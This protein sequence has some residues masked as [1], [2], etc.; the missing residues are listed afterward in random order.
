MLSS[1]LNFNNLDR[2][3]DYQHIYYNVDIVNARTSASQSDPVASFNETRDTSIVSDASKYKTSIIRFTMN[4]IKDLPLFI[5]IIEEDQ[6]DRNKTIYK[7]SIKS[8]STVITKNIMF[9]PENSYLSLGAQSNQKQ[10][11]TD[12]Y[13]YVHTYNHM[14]KLLNDTFQILITDY[15]TTAGGSFD[16]PTMVYNTDSKKFDFY[17]PFDRN[18]DLFFDRNLYNL[19][20]NYPSIRNLN[21]DN[22]S[23]QILAEDPLGLKEVSLKGK[24]YLKIEQEYNSIG[25]FWSPIES[26]VFT[27]NMLP[28]V[29]EGVAP[30]SVYGKSNIST[31]VSSATNFEPIITDIALTLDDAYN[32]KEFISYIPTSQYRYVSH[33]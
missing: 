27:S 11:F 5:S 2:H 6:P 14:V 21:D 8:G 30:T 10:N 23:Y 22:L 31:P 7:I 12:E 20:S 33:L 24:N 4:G 3:K 28:I 9:S 1:S 26:I 19:F 29:S 25:T 17:I 13:Y 18:Y 15:N 32:H 16:P